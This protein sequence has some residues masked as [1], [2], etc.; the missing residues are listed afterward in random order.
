[1][2]N[3]LRFSD[4]TAEQLTDVKNL[5]E[6]MSKIPKQQRMLVTMSAF[7]FISGMEAQMMLKEPEKSA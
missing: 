5:A 4:Y 6:I 7:A 3:K 1:M 2:S